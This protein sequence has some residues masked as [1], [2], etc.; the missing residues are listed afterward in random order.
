MGWNVWRR[1]KSLLGAS[2]PPTDEWEPLDNLIKE[3][4]YV[5]DNVTGAVN[6]IV[7]DQVEELVRDAA[8][9]AVWDGA[10]YVLQQLPIL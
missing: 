2:H 3:M 1:L 5:Y 4:G 9:N 8:I 6:Y 7:E 10:H